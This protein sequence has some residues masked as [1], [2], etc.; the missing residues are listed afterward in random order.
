MVFLELWRE[1]LGS[2]GVAM[3]TSGTS[4]VASGK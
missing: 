3:G 2:S 4:L 1:A